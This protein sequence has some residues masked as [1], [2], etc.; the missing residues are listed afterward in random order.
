MSK[1]WLES[2][3]KHFKND[4][5]NWV[6][7]E[8]VR[9]SSVFF[10]FLNFNKVEC[11]YANRIDEIIRKEYKL[12]RISVFVDASFMTIDIW[13]PMY[14]RFMHYMSILIQDLS[15]RNIINNTEAVVL[16]LWNLD[17]ILPCHVCI[18]HYKQAKSNETKFQLIQNAFYKISY[19]FIIAGV[20]DFH[21]VINYN[22]NKHS[23]QR[24]DFITMYRCDILSYATISFEYC[25]SPVYW[26]PPTFLLLVEIAA[27]ALNKHPFLIYDSLNSHLPLT[28]Y[29]P[30]S[31]EKIDIDFS[32]IDKYVEEHQDA[33]VIKRGVKVLSKYF[34]FLPSTSADI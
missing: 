32:V 2:I 12:E 31:K 18:G 7:E 16:M 15:Y 11:P 26:W 28:K 5:E 17:K 3:A 1:L 23:P 34:P 21:N 19:G 14:W 30:Y 9:S 29:Q 6:I 22:L 10:S 33:E 25:R 4:T 27:R 20:Y 24:S 13:G 8:Y